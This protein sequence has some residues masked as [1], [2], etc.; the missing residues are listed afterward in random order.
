MA[1]TVVATLP[2]QWA[3][4][5]YRSIE[6][7]PEIVRTGRTRGR[8]VYPNPRRPARYQLYTRAMRKGIMPTA[9]QQRH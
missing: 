4:N 3:V 5:N 6:A 8:R 7:L 9:N 1:D 2:A